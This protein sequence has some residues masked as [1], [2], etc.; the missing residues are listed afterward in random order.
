MS[1]AL[2]EAYLAATPDEL[3]SR[4]SARRVGGLISQATLFPHNGT[5][6][7]TE[8]LL[9]LSGYR[10]LRPRDL[11]SVEQRF[12]PEYG[13]FAA[14]GVRGGFPSMGF[15]TRQGAPLVLHLKTGERII[16]LLGFER[17]SGTTKNR[18]WLDALQAFAQ[19]A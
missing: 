12:V 1:Q 16:V 9:V 11:V 13:R 3:R 18:K 7:L 10:T 19:R 2:D 4:S 6:T 17:I 14:G 8:N 5:M 15:I